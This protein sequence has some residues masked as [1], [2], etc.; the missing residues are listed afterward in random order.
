MCIKKLQTWDRII[1]LVGTSILQERTEDEGKE[2]HFIVLQVE[3]KPPSEIDKMNN[4]F[5]MQV[6]KLSQR[7][8]MGGDDGFS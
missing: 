4:A 8:Y 1:L 6:L 2:K 5:L 3:S 7:K